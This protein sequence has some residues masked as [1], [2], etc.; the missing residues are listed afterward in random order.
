MP[1]YDLHKQT[2]DEW[3]GLAAWG[4][5][6]HSYGT[7]SA[8]FHHR[9]IV[10]INLTSYRQTHDLITIVNSCGVVSFS[11]SLSKKNSLIWS[12][13][14]EIIWHFCISGWLVSESVFFVNFSMYIQLNDVMLNTSITL[15]SYQPKWSLTIVGFFFCLF[16][17]KTSSDF[18]ICFKKWCLSVK[19]ILAN[20]RV[21]IINFCLLQNSLVSLQK[22]VIAAASL[23]DVSLGQS[24][25]QIWNTWP[26]SKM[27]KKKT[28][29]QKK[30]AAWL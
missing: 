1:L 14:K 30:T 8:A 15:F 29:K 25:K 23:L 22:Y 13:K 12:L 21:S 27:I 4:K 17:F 11:H 26:E 2:R 28:N 9:C 20:K 7:E 3:R 24:C 6:L 10:V 19:V 16:F 5:K 18:Y